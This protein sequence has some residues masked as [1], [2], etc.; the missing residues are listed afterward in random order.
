M[1]EPLPAVVPLEP[2]VLPSPVPAGE[3]P[4]PDGVETSPGPVPVVGVGIPEE[5]V[6]PVCPPA[7][8]VSVEPV[9]PAVPELLPVP[10]GASGVVEVVEPAP[11]TVGGVC[12]PE[13]GAL[14]GRP[15][16]PHPASASKRLNI[17]DLGYCCTSLSCPIQRQRK[18]EDEQCPRVRHK[19][20][21]TVRFT[22][23]LRSSQ[24]GVSRD[25]TY[26]C[27]HFTSRAGCLDG[28]FLYPERCTPVALCSHVVIFPVIVALVQRDR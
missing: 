9:E 16:V 18:G 5:A 24:S 21:F 28:Y 22:N 8:G 4:V 20:R 7:A 15:T 1:P 26:P 10:T 3:L 25:L 14:T 11:D 19:G 12:A 23:R 6:A 27:I 17:N 13:P 2:A